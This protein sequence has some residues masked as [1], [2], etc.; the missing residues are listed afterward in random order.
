MD[1]EIQRLSEAV[2]DAAAHK[3]P[4]RIRGGGSKDFYGGPLKGDPLDVTAYRGIVSYEPTELVLTARA[5]TPLDEI[6]AALREKGQMLAFEPPHYGPGATFGGC[7]ATGLSGPR[8][9]YAGSV[10]DYVLGVRILDG[11]GDDLRFGGQV[12]KNVAGYDVSRLMTGSL[13]TLGVLLE[14]SLKVLP[15]PTIEVTLRLK[16][17]EPQAIALINSWAGKPL[18]VSATLFGGSELHVRL[19]GS[20]AGVDAA[21]KKVGGE[22]I[23]PETAERLWSGVREHTNAFFACDGPLWRLSVKPTTPPLGLPGTHLIE[24]GGALRWLRSDAPA[25]TIRDAAAQA[26]GHATLFRGGDKSIGVF[27]PLPPALMKLHRNLKHAMDPAGILNPG[28][29][30]ADL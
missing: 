16:C 18:P 7:I 14:V 3:R 28:R 29:L 20:H 12:M 10:R 30:Y 15:L 8:R 25:Q 27:H 2:R 6:E 4:L 22:T 26:G 5:G 11:K 13:G 23:A 1:T 17:G 21:I 24:W 19:S 9:P